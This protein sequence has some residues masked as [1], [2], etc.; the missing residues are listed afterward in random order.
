MTRNVVDVA[1]RQTGFRPQGNGCGPNTVVCVDL[2]KHG[3]CT[4]FSHHISERI[5]AK[6][7][8]FVPDVVCRVQFTPVAL[9]DLKKGIALW[10]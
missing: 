3:L 4:Y 8:V 6:R 10:V 9:G 2:G 1:I 7:S 5:D